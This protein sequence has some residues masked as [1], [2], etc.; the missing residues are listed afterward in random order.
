ML[1]RKLN[2][3]SQD[4]DPAAAAHHYDDEHDDE[5]ASH[6]WAIGAGPS[7]ITAVPSA[8]CSVSEL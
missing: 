2:L 5:P 6:G 4:R 3:V 7:R 8:V 1:A